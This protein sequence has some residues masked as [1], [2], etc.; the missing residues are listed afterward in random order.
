MLVLRSWQSRGCTS[1]KINADLSLYASIFKAISNS[2]FALFYSSISKSQPDSLQ[3]RFLLDE[4]M[5]LSQEEATFT[6]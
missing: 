3:Q 4:W 1:G 2:R 5:F 6:F